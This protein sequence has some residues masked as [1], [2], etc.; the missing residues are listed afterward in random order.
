MNP[1]PTNTG[2]AGKVWVTYAVT[3][4]LDFTEVPSNCRTQHVRAYDETPERQTAV[5]EF[6]QAVEPGVVYTPETP[7]R[8]RA[9]DRAFHDELRLRVGQDAPG[10]DDNGT[11]PVPGTAP[12][13]KLVESRAGGE[14]SA[15]VV[16]VPITSESG[17]HQRGARRNVGRKDPR[18]LQGEGQ[19]VRLRHE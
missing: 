6:D 17:V 19:V 9:L 11:V 16:D 7:L 10:A 14:G 2:A 1:Y 5:C 18:L 15:Q 12:A 3:R 4:G 8:V 13:V